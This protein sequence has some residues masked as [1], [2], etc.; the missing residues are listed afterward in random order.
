L[1]R[2]TG[3]YLPSIVG[4][5]LIAIIIYGSYWHSLR[6]SAESYL[7]SGISHAASRDYDE[8]VA[9]FSEAIR[10]DSQ[11]ALAFYDR[12]LAYYLKKDTVRALADYDQAVRLDPTYVD[13]YFNRGQTHGVLQN[14]DA[15][16]GDFSTVIRLNPKHVGAFVERGNAYRAKQDFDRAS[17]D[18]REAIR[19]R[20]SLA[21][22]LALYN[23]GRLKIKNGDQA[24]GEADIIAARKAINSEAPS[25]K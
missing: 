9:D 25:F 5:S 4:A 12:G 10:M 1:I 16:I 18:F 14:L 21:S 2:R 19:L 11:F 6:K 7:R 17:A 20:P 24:G 8:A 23:R 15:A 13:A 22:D 3:V